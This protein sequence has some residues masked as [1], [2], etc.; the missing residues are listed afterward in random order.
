MLSDSLL[1]TGG[2][3]PESALEQLH[4]IYMKLLHKGLL[5]RGAIVSGELHLEPRIT[6]ATF[7]KFLLSMVFENSPF[8][9]TENS[10][11]GVIPWPPVWTGG[12]L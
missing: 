6:R 4:L 10:P 12:R 9:V 11:L 1:I 2:A 5:L 7:E 8:S 3:P